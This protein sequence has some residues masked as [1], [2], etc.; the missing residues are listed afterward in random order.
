M[1]SRFEYQEAH[2]ALP[3]RLVLYATNS[4]LANAAAAA[5]FQRV[6]QLNDIMSDYDTDSELSLLS[7]TSGEGKAVPISDDLWRVL[8]RAQGLAVFSEGAFDVTV[9]P[10]VNLWR[11]AR[12]EKKLPD[13]TWLANAR[14]ASGYENLR[15]E[16][17]RQTAEL[18]VPDMRIDL[19]GI[20]KGDAIDQA[21]KVLRTNGINRALVTG[22]GDMAAGDPPPGKRGWRIELPPL[23]ATNAP[24]TRF[25]LLS[26]AALAT[27]GDLF[28]R[29]E[30][31]GKRYSHI[32]D[33]RTGI[34]LTD[35]S[36]VTVIARDCMTADSL[37]KVVSVLGP[38]KGFLIVHE[39]PSAAARVVRK[40]GEEIELRETRTFRRFYDSN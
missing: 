1:L 21:L 20:A 37:T 31:D 40:P 25:V 38:E 19:G 32:V 15:L 14:K 7:R 17:K 8:E 23:D 29:L 10:L 39:H 34:G 35:H 9:G 22:G 3:F 4:A 11:K 12:R 27:S 13:P 5:A 28:Q 18:L 33:P 30:I 36:L 24:P 2:M 26:N 6:A 16:P